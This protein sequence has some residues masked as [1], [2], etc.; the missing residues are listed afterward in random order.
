[1]LSK[2]LKHEFRLLIADKTVWIVSLLFAL[3]TCYAVWSGVAR[4]KSELD[5]LQRYVQAHEQLLEKYRLRAEAIE[6]IKAG[7]EAGSFNIHRNELTWGPTQPGYVPAWA[8][9]F[10]A[11]PP[12]STAALATGHSDIHPAV[13]AVPYWTREMQPVVDPSGNP[14]KLLVG[15]FDL[16]FVTLFLLPP[17]L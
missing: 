11:L 16:S 6:R 7:K 12:A 8:P 9:F 5:G 2:I 4:T 10:A 13:L 14:L 15:H 1:V 17:Y 3:A